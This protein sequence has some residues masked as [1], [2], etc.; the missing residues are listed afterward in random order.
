MQRPNLEVEEQ[1]PA[2][3]VAEAEGIQLHLSS[4]NAT[5]Y[6]GVQF[7]RE[8][9]FKVVRSGTHLGFFKTAVDAAVDAAAG[10]AAVMAASKGGGGRCFS[11]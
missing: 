10:K 11:S 9:R 5:G 7:L 8:G 6:K 1:P 4:A 3:V 2:A